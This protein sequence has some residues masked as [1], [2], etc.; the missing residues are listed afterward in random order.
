VQEFVTSSSRCDQSVSV[1]RTGGQSGSVSFLSNNSDSAAN[2][3]VSGSGVTGAGGGSGGGFGSGG[4]RAAIPNERRSRKRK[5]SDRTVRYSDTPATSGKTT[6]T[7][8]TTSME[9]RPEAHRRRSL[10]RELYSTGSGASGSSDKAPLR[11]G[12]EG[13]GGAGSTD[14]PSD[15]Q[16]LL[17]KSPRLGA[18][19][20]GS[21][22]PDLCLDNALL[23]F[24]SLDSKEPGR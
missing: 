3:E 18:G 2:G 11:L 7:T 21:G 23:R 9:C 15:T 5:S 13:E 6:T 17:R 24:H 1:L 22:S 4:G 16:P 19:E 14:C 20:G 10:A 8:T 12:S